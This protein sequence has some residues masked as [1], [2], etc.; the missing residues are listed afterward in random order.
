VSV[1]RDPTLV[2]YNSFLF[3]NQAIKQ[4]GFSDIRSSNDGNN[5][6]HVLGIMQGEKKVSL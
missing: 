3:F 6:A 5:S 1:T 4:G 2:I